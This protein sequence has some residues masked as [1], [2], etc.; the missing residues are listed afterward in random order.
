ML[1]L[2]VWLER[3]HNMVEYTE[4]M[5]TMSINGFLSSTHEGLGR[6]AQVYHWTQAV[7]LHIREEC[8]GRPLLFVV[9]RNED[10]VRRHHYVE[11]IDSSFPSENTE[12]SESRRV[13]QVG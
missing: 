5:P 6:R 10:C 11:I 12:S 7:W 3:G 8:S 9:E 1:K 4:N 13:W 2:R